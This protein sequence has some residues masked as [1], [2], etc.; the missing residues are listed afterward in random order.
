MAVQINVSGVTTVKVGT[1]ASG[2]LETLGK[3][4]DMIDVHDE[5]FFHEVPGDAHGGPQGPPIDIQFLGRVVRGRVELYTYDRTVFEGLRTRIVG[6]TDGS[7]VDGDIGDLL[8]QDD[9]AIRVLLDNTNDPMNF[10]LCQI[11][12]A[13]DITLGTKFSTAVFEFTAHPGRA[14][15]LPD[16]GVTIWLACP[17]VPDY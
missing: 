11:T 2:A 15:A 3:A 6:G 9:K 1:G 4:L 10:P 7:V 17:P 8:I 13:C 16:N 14:P 12:S 5:P